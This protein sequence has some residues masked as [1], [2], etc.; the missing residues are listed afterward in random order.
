[1]I[2][3]TKA[4]GIIQTVQSQRT[5]KFNEREIQQVSS[6]SIFLSCN[7]NI[8][9]FKLGTAH[10]SSSWTHDV[11][12]DFVDFICWKKWYIHMVKSFLQ[13][14]KELITQ[15]KYSSPL[16]PIYRFFLQQSWW[17]CYACIRK[18]KYM[19][20][21]LFFTLW[22]HT[23]Q[24]LLHLLFSLNDRKQEYHYLGGTVGNFIFQ[25]YRNL[26]DISYIGGH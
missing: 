10:C 4:V 17:S 12:P 26:F 2:C 21:E 24:T 22:W 18:Y 13:S 14:M 16:P 1:M 20:L 6:I 8:Y 11:S 19:F 25:I 9:C 7:R 3:L 15:M 23:L 5:V